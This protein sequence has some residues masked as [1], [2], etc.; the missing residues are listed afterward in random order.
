MHSVQTRCSNNSRRGL[1]I[2]ECSTPVCVLRHVCAS[3]Y[4]FRLPLVPFAL[5]PLHL[6]A[7]MLCHMS[8]LRVA[9]SPGEPTMAAAPAG[10]PGAIGG[11]MDE[12][13][14]AVVC[15]FGPVQTAGGAGAGNED[16]KR[17]QTQAAA[18]LDQLKAQPNAW[19]MAFQLFLKTTRVEVRFWCLQVRRC[20]A[21]VTPSNAHPHARGCVRCWTASLTRATTKRCHCLAAL[22]CV[23]R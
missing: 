5:P 11:S 8:H 2:G 21:C 3:V 23:L 18:Y 10:I 14:R 13:E 9:K 17:L 4:S 16:A 20:V 6:V 12:V 19:G 1:S 15:A 22:K 7:A